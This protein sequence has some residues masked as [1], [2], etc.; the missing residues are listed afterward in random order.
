MKTEVVV[1]L[2]LA[3]VVALVMLMP[4]G[5]A[6]VSM[7]DARNFVLEDMKTKY[8]NAEITEVISSKEENGAYK[9]KGRVSSALSSPCP[10][11]LH[12]YYDYPVSH[13]VT[14]V[15][16]ITR[17]C[18]VCEGL[19]EC[20]IAFEE[21]AVAA[22]HTYAGSE[23]VGAYLVKYPDAKASYELL[24]EFE[25]E[26]DVWHVTWE[27]AYAA[28]KMNVYLSKNKNSILWVREEGK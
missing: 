20:V 24:S 19:P 26:T 7:Q 15:E 5:N 2:L 17:N 6:G 12:L 18:K 9:I 22:S 11:R 1:L 27:G 28:V 21:E 23:R 8:P 3:I 14:W 25:G 4:K 13:F 10:Q 16:N